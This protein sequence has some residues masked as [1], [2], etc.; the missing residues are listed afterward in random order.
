LPGCGPLGGIV[1]AL[2]V[3]SSPWNLITACDMPRL[4]SD[5]LAGLLRTAAA[6]P[7]GFDCLVPMGP[8]GPEPLC[9]VYH[10]QALP[11]LR[12]ALER[13]MLK[14]RRVLDSLKVQYHSVPDKDR[15][16]NINTPTDWLE[17]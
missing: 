9:A 7:A 10:R 5:F 17:Q 13:N 1:T 11:E 6:L 15:F 8:A 4:D 3:T 16:L 14:M 2:E 12:A